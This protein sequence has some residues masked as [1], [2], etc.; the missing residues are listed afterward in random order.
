MSIPEALYIVSQNEHGVAHNYFNEYLPAILLV[1]ETWPHEG[2][3]VDDGD[4]FEEA[5][6]HDQQLMSDE[7][8]AQEWSD[9]R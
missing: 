3:M 4:G 1:N 8:K 5:L 2:R 7:R 6:E 9:R